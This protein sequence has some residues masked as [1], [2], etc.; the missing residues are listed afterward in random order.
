[1]SYREAPKELPPRQRDVEWRIQVARAAQLL[2]WALLAQ[3]VLWSWAHLVA[4]A[5]VTWLSWKLS[6]PRPVTETRDRGVLRWSLRGLSVWALAIEVLDRL[7]P[8]VHALEKLDHVIRLGSAVTVRYAT[9]S[10]D[11]TLSGVI[12]TALSVVGLLYVRELFREFSIAQAA[13]QALR[14]TWRYLARVGVITGAVI[15]MGLV[16]AA[17]HGLK[18]VSLLLQIPFVIATALAFFGLIKVAIDALKLLRRLRATLH[19]SAHEWWYRPGSGWASLAIATGNAEVIE[20]AGGRA[21][22][23]DRD[24]AVEWLRK[25]DYVPA[26]QAIAERTVLGA[27]EPIVVHERAPRVRARVASDAPSTPSDAQANSAVPEDATETGEDSTE[28]AQ[29]ATARRSSQG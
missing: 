17:A 16:E 1:V 8:S 4:M 18:G 20:A 6:E 23:P 28:D 21:L 19:V 27:P 15:A 26:S 9:G 12:H 13:E 7:S 11:L 10:T 5:V 22:F 2:F 29:R 24:Q 14:L 25:S 3:M